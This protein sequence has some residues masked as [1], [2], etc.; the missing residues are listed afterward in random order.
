MNHTIRNE[1]RVYQ[2]PPDGKGGEWKVLSPGVKAFRRKIGYLILSE[3][4]VMNM[5]KQTK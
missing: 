2:I 1:T 3:E 5:R 4:E